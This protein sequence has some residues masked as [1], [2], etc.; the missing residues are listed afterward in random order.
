M[1]CLEN[2]PSR[3]S[4]TLV[5]QCCRSVLFVLAIASLSAASVQLAGVTANGITQHQIGAMCMISD[6]VTRLT[7]ERDK[8]MKL[9]E[10]KQKKL[11]ERVRSRPTAP[12]TYSHSEHQATYTTES[13]ALL[14]RYML[15]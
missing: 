10:A 8:E 11:T 9:K 14:V 5:S 7:L 12:G 13:N 2:S 3:F 4:L 6:E 1:R 15:R